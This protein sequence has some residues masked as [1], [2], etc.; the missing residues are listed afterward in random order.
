MWDRGGFWTWLG[1][2]NSKW[3]ELVR[4]FVMPQVVL[5]VQDVVVVYFTE[6]LRW[7]IAN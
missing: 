3:A 4:L 7:S 2:A 6:T 5:I 1:H